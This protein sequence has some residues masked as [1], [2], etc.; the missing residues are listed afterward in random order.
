MPQ[1]NL[2][3]TLMVDRGVYDAAITYSFFDIVTYEGNTY[4]AVSSDIQAGILPVDSPGSWQLLS[5]KGIQGDKGLTGDIGPKG[6]SGETG[7]PGVSGDP[8]AI[9]NVYEDTNAMAADKQNIALGQLVA[10]Q[11]LEPAEG[12][13]LYAQLYVRVEDSQPSSPI[14][15]KYLVNLQGESGVAGETGI[16]GETG[17]KLF[18]S[19]LTQQQLEELKGAKGDKGDTGDRGVAGF[20]FTPQVSNS[21]LS[22]TNNGSLAN[23]A[24]VNLKGDPGTDGAKGDTGDKGPD[25][26]DGTDGATITSATVNANGELIVTLSR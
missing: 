5:L 15:F 17:D 8:I 20:L 11:T 16:K 14:G 1:L 19:D 4:V 21:V 18:R 2:G 6:E 26:A 22:W 23:P 10:I 3:R 7:D 25:G 13:P 9:T 12:Q 24:G